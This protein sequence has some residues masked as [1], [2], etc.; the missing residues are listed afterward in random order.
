MTCFRVPV[1]AQQVKNLTVSMRMQVQSLALLSGLRIQHCPKL[2]CRSQM[3]LESG[4]AAV[5]ASVGNCS[6]LQ[7]FL[8][9]ELLYAT[10]VTRKKKKKKKKKNFLHIKENKYNLLLIYTTNVNLST[11]MFFAI[12]NAYSLTGH[13]YKSNIDLQNIHNIM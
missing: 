13:V 9:Q 12:S 11:N 5:V 1:V 7:K 3:W 6:W 4:V 10:S 2:Q 8:A